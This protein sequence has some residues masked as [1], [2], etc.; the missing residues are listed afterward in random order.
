[1]ISAD[2]VGALIAALKDKT[3]DDHALWWND[4]SDIDRD[5]VIDL[6]PEELGILDGIPGWALDR[7]LRASLPAH[8]ERLNAQ[9]GEAGEARRQEIADKI[10]SIEELQQV[11]TEPERQLLAVSTEGTRAKAAVAVGDVDTAVHIGV[12]TPGMGST[13]HGCIARYDDE[14]DR[15]R[16]RAI[17]LGRE[18]A[19]VAS[20]T[21]LGYDAPLGVVDVA[22]RDAAIAGSA[23]LQ[24]FTDGI[25][26]PREDR[27]HLVALG[28]SYGSTTTALSLIKREHRIDD[29]VFFGSPGLATNDLAELGLPPGHVY[30][31]EAKGDPVADLGYFG[32]DP[33]W[34]Q[35]IVILS[36]GPS[37]VG[38]EVS[39]HANYLQEGS[40]SQHN[41]AA[42]VA[43]LPDL[44]VGGMVPGFGDRVRQVI[45]FFDRD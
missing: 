35:Q 38:I 14:M 36:T 24:R 9:R 41:I 39:G 43:G 10:A 26:S 20:V 6:A 12:Y 1:M 3:P 18:P 44:V 23:L 29:A 34:L 21:W 28:H 37:H 33:N 31:L 32:N 30:L 27:F 15:L 40:T 5:A 2:T 4:L 22:Q 8:L 11:L 7:A 25:R 17:A 42:V 16:S 19:E 45:E 13:V